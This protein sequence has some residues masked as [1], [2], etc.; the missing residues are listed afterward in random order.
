MIRRP[1][2]STRTDTLF[3]Y[4]THFRSAA[5]LPMLYQAH[6]HPDPVSYRHRTCLKGI[7]GI[8]HGLIL[9]DA[10]FDKVSLPRAEE[11]GMAGEAPLNEVELRFAP[12]SAEPMLLACVWW[13][14]PGDPLPSFKKLGQASCRAREGPY[15]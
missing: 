7:F 6:P 15:V 1:P 3:P 8:S 13:Q 14:K 4:T 2:R 11:N 9:A 12:L 5:M 10:F